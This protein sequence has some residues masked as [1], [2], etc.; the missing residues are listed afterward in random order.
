[1]ADLSAEV[2]E[3]AIQWCASAGRRTSAAEV[4]AA[5]GSLPWE[6][7]VTATALLADPPPARPLGPFALA[8][9]AR[10]VSPESAAERELALGA[11][12]DGDLSADA[13]RSPGDRVRSA[14]GKKRGPSTT[15]V[16]IRRARDRVPATPSAPPSLPLVDELLASEGRAQLDQMV[17]RHGARRALLVQELAAGW[18][19]EDGAVPGDDDLTELL[20]AHDLTRV[21]ER[22]E[23]DLV[24]HTIRA[25]GGVRA[26]AAAAL[27]LEPDAFQALL[28]RL[29]AEKD[30]ER[31]RAERSKELLSQATLSERVHQLSQDE[32][33]LADL[34]ILDQV[35][36]DLR[37][38][39]P[40]H[41]RAMRASGERAL[42]IALGRTLSLS[43]PSVE[44]L[45]QR[46]ALDLIGGGKRPAARSMR[47]PA[48]SER[49]PEPAPDV[50]PSSHDPAADPSTHSPTP[51][52]S[53]R[54]RPSGPRSGD[55]H[56]SDPPFSD[57]PPG[58]GASPRRSPSDRSPGR[59]FSPGRPP[60]DRP[61]GRAFSP[62]RPPSGR[63]PGRPFSP[64]RPSS[65]R[66]PERAFSPGR[67]SSG[68]PPGRPFSPGRPSSGRPPERAFSPGRPSS[69]R[70]PERSFSPGRPPSGR[71]P[72]RPFSPGRPPSGRPP[73]RPFS[74]GRPSS[75]GPPERSFSPGRPPSGRPPGRPFSPG[76]APSGRPPGRGSSPGRPPARGPSSGRRGPPRRGPAR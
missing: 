70:P 61:P 67:P 35:L 17:R 73:G 12:P 76:R 9:L 42:A 3:R 75:G 2:I 8:D 21:F 24:L 72:G 10:G 54:R 5:L 39:L 40:E 69:S 6:Q 66:P 47:G 59:P 60:S 27:S 32:E 49:P 28:V 16:T 51:E 15:P 14:K 38:R 68:R 71:P 29:D 23:H 11:L 65:G 57:R 55:G 44:A 52:A 50:A 36:A 19:R 20:E 53:P 37:V 46:F 33:R 7:L 74:P 1:M 26:R 43:R 62:G 58:R 25:A 18:R 56:V 64:G 30:V 22:R 13:P 45:A 4:R 41:L 63:P 31:I 48:P 34:G